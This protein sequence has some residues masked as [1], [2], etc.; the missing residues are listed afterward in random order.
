MSASFL[1]DSAVS[2]AE[3]ARKGNGCPLSVIMRGGRTR[4]EEQ[5]T[6]F[7]VDPDTL[8]RTPTKDKLPVHV[9]VEMAR[10]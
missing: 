10:K 4:L 3:D 2:V 7:D 1:L 5:D 8:Q 9:S 6:A